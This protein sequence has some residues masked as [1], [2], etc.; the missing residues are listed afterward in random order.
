[1]TALQKYSD[2]VEHLNPSFNVESGNVK[3]ALEAQKQ[4]YKRNDRSKKKDPHFG[5]PTDVL[6]IQQVHQVAHTIIAKQKSMHLLYSWTMLFATLV[7]GNFFRDLTL[8]HMRTDKVNGPLKPDGT[9]EPL[10]VVA[11]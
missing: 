1:M 9:R 7:R 6:S 11:M 4:F 2:T 8:S 3:A 10:R 5:L